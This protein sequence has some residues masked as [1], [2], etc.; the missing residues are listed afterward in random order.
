MP[1][2]RGHIYDRNG[3]MIAENVPGYTVSMLSPSG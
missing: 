1:A 3:E 2:P